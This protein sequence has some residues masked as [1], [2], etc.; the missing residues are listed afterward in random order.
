MS[1][2]IDNVRFVD[3]MNVATGRITPEFI[4]DSLNL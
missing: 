2:K 1:I 4:V 3:I